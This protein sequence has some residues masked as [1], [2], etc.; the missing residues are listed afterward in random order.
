MPGAPAGWEALLERFG[1]LGGERVL[2]PAI[3]HAAH[4]YV[5]AM[6]HEGSACSLIQGVYDPFGS[7]VVARGFSSTIAVPGS[8]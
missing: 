5:A 6:D 1:R 4:V 8:C 3:S 7:G 2:A